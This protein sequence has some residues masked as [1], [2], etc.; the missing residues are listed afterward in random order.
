MK[1]LLAC[2]HEPYTQMFLDMD[3]DITVCSPF[4]FERQWRESYRPKPRWENAP[5]PSEYDLVVSMGLP[6]INHLVRF[7]VPTLL[8]MLNMRET[9]A[10]NAPN[11]GFEMDQRAFERTRIAYISQKKR[12]SWVQAGFPHG[13]I[14]VS[15][16]NPSWYGG[17]T[18]EIG[19]VLRVGN[20]MQARSEMQGWEWANEAT[21]GLVE[22]VVG[23]N[24]GVSEAAGS[25]EE[26]KSHYRENRVYLNS[27][28][29]ELEDGYNL[30]MIEAML[31]GM[32]V[33]TRCNSSSPITH[34]VDGFVAESPSDARLYLKQLLSDRPLAQRMGAH[35]QKTAMDTFG[36]ERFTREWDQVFTD[37]VENVDGRSAD[38]VVR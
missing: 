8:V 16:L 28:S 10:P 24:P 37:T 14:V 3:H 38:G 26:L 18:G 25:W 32:P 21:E 6:D 29:D 19:R 11:L 2:W 1:V 30:G 15:G 33:V 36:I 12:D 7:D 5:K 31:T 4:S 9:D 13:P 22:K 35:A 20:Q 34:G 23:E 27:L 17:Y